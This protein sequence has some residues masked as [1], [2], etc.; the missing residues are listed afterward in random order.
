MSAYA[1]L[2]VKTC[3]ARGAHAIGGMAAFVPSRSNPEATTAALEKTTADK[4][5]EAGLGF[6][7]SWVAHPALVQTCTDAFTEVLGERPNQLE[8]QRPDVAVTRDELVDVSSTEGQVTLEGLRTN[9]RVSLEYLAAWVGGAGAVA[10]DNLMEDAATVE[11]S[12]MQIWH[13]VRHGATTADG[14][15]VTDDLVR[16]L[17]EELVDTLSEGAD[18][19]RST[20]VSSAQQ[21]FE[22]TCLV[23]EWPQFFT[24]YAYEHYLASPVG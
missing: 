22:A 2:L 14:T 7:G 4:S 9:I 17:L 19:R 5:R 21:V 15:V 16:R 3:H 12:R 13:W 6:D 18:D 24:T 8:H 20:L 1:N 23:P 11:I 10:I